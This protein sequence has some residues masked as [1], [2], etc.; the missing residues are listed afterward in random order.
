MGFLFFPIWVRGSAWRP[1]GPPEL[2]YKQGFWSQG[3]H[4]EMPLVLAGKVFEEIIIKNA[5]IFVLR[6][7]FC[8]SFESSLLACAP[9]PNIGL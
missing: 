7:D 2:G 1:F 3:V 5:L 9:I 6:L 8:Q 4:D